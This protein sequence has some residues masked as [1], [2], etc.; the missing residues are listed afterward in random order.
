M[1]AHPV[2]FAVTIVSHDKSFTT[3]RTACGRSLEG[4]ERPAHTTED[5]TQVT[6]K[7]CLR[8]PDFDP[9]LYRGRW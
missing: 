4:L 7:R 2:H 6:C 8:S 1:P 9:V 3:H 5:K